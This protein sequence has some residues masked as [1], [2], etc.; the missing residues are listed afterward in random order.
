M[1]H[2]TL[3]QMGGVGTQLEQRKESKKGGATLIRPSSNNFTAVFYPLCPKEWR[4]VF[5]V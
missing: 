1:V 2:S 3:R 4:F 5:I